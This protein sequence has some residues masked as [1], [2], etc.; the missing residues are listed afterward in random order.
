MSERDID[1]LFERDA[2][3]RLVERRRAKE[4]GLAPHP[5]TATAS[6]TRFGAESIRADEI[7]VSRRPAALR[8]TLEGR[9]DRELIP[10]TLVTLVVTVANDGDVNAREAVLRIALPPEAEP[11]DGSFSRDD[12]SI[13]HA[14][15]TGEGLRLGTIPPAIETRLRFAVHVLSG[16]EPL[17]I[18]AHVSADGV[19]AVGV[20][21]LR[22]R[23]R[24][25]HA[26][27]AQP[28]PF[29][30][31][32]EGEQHEDLPAEV[33]EAAEQRVDAV[34]DEI[35]S[36][37]IV[38][39]LPQ[40]EPEPAP[41]E[42]PPRVFLTR[43]IGA[44]DVRS[45]DRVFAGGVP[46]GLAAFALLTGIA[47]TSGSASEALGLE[48]FRAAVAA[49]LPRALVAARMRKPTPA[50]VTYEALDA[51]RPNGNVTPSNAAPDGTT[52]VAAFD[53]PDVEGLYAVLRRD[54]EDPFLR[55]TQV[56]LA[57]LPR[58]IEGV[59]ADDARAVVE[60]LSAFRVTAGA[61]LMR[62]TVRRAVDRR[63]DPLTADDAALRDAGT[64]LIA[65]LREVLS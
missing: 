16:T 62:V 27:F 39:P 38:A 37:E 11:V 29:F 31:L 46:H 6:V 24:E 1:A 51:I 15:L 20:P 49:T 13:D 48:A 59:G 40:P 21:A 63:Y 18:G 19:P 53:G 65:A 17:D 52:L 50:I 56:L 45:F 36:P 60:A 32:E 34:I 23:R 64:A 9:P 41:R 47:C 25:G 5:P 4:L 28:K 43:P 44:A 22:L 42:R 30:E 7:K 8:V 55:G 61:W 57:I 58:E 2:D 10:G 54:L 26:A 12:I 14:A 35:A 33:G 3:S